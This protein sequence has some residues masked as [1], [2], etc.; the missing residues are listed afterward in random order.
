MND[1][2]FWRYQENIVKKNDNRQSIVK[3]ILQKLQKKMYTNITN[4]NVDRIQKQII[5]S[6]IRLNRNQQ[7]NIFFGF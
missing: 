5:S 1:I 6:T 3:S 4:W 7:V 2:I